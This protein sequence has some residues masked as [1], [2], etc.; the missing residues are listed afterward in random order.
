MVH[1]GMGTLVQIRVSDDVHRVLT[2]RASR[3]RGSDVEV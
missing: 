2:A 1:F 3:G